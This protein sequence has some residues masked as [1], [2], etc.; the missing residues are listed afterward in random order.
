MNSDDMAV[1]I[2]HR[3]LMGP[4]TSLQHFPPEEHEEM[5]EHLK[6][7]IRDILETHGSNA[8]DSPRS[9]AIAHEVGHAIVLAH[10]GIPVEKIAVWKRAGASEHTWEGLTT[11]KA[12]TFFIDPDT[13][14]ITAL[15]HACFVIAGEVGE[16]VLDPDTY[17]AGTALDEVLFSQRIAYALANRVKMTEENLWQ[18]IRKR[19]WQ[20]IA[21]N[22]P[23]AQELIGRLDRTESLQRRALTT[24]LE[25]VKKI[26]D[27]WQWLSAGD[28][29]AQ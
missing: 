21:Y 16:K 23:V 2:A 11:K 26:P 14:I 18:E 6:R 10:D 3:L 13:P 4:S 25:R 17:R 7:V 27:D 15:S 12:R 1:A 22:E 29:A 5:L 24:P 19:S 20:I 8:F 28:L 9:A